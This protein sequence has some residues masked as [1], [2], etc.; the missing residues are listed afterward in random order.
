MLIASAY[1]KTQNLCLEYDSKQLVKKIILHFTIDPTAFMEAIR[2]NTVHLRLIYTLLKLYTEPSQWISVE[3]AFLSESD[4][5]N[6]IVDFQQHQDPSLMLIM[7]EDALF[8][9]L[10]STQIDSD[11]LGKIVS[12]QDKAGTYIAELLAFSP[13]YLTD[14]VNPEFWKSVTLSFAALNSIEE[15][16]FTPSEFAKAF[17]MHLLKKLKAVN[18]EEMYYRLLD[19]MRT[20]DLPNINELYNLLQLPDKSASH[21]ENSNSTKIDQAE[22]DLSGEKLAHYFSAA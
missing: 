5:K 6:R 7:H 17:A 9:E 18:E 16:E 3:K 22:V 2:K 21:S 19:Q 8:Q 10:L 11:A 12:S 1:Q 20:S 13:G 14:K 15:K 4:F